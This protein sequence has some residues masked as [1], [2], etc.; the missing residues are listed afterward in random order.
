MRVLLEHEYRRLLEARLGTDKLGRRM[1]LESQPDVQ[2]F[3]QGLAWLHPKNWLMSASLVHFTLRATFLLDRARRNALGLEVRTRDVIIPALPA[4]FDGFTILHMSDLHLD[5]TPKFPEVLADRI[6]ELEY[7]LCVL[8]GDY[9]Y[10]VQGSCAPATEGL[11]RLKASISSPVFSVL[12]NHDSIE[13][14]SD[15]EEMGIRVL[16]NEGVDLIEQ[17]ERIYLCGIDDPHFFRTDDLRVARRTVPDG[18]VSILL[19]HSPEVYR[20]AAEAGFA[21]MLCGH[22]HGG[23]IR[24]PGGFPI[25]FNARCPR[26]F[27]NG[28]W[29]QGT[30]QGYTSVGAGSSVVDARL[31]CTPE[32]TLHRLRSGVDS[33]NASTPPRNP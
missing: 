32:V 33:P 26:R 17:G 11:Q 6:E 29:E 23:Q 4:A 16:L 21:V 1:E 22:T 8:T 5:M 20:E 13:M 19:S 27:C 30:M 9:R 7:D 31:N 25:L 12:G 24:L 28:A 15:M 2:I 14:V 18:A 3:G 10:Q